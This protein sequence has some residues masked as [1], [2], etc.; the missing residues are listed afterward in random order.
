MGNA[1]VKVKV[2]AKKAKDASTN[3][4]KPKRHA[5]TK[6]ANAMISPYKAQRVS[7]VL[8][9][10]SDPTRIAIL[11]LLSNG[12]RSDQSLSAALNQSPA[13]FGPHLALLGQ[14]KLV[15]A[16]K[17]AARNLYCLT[18]Q[19]KRLASF[20]ATI[21]SSTLVSTPFAAVGSEIDP[22]LL[23]DVGEIIEN[24]EAWFNTPNPAFEGRRPRELLGTADETRLR[25]QIEAAKYGMF[26]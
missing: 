11:A 23:K 5:G 19:G 16:R 4:T 18:L 14:A 6:P 9:N 20:L 3:A 15:A 2:A 1:K 24:P 7:N 8:R 25:N 21:S 22:G 13:A 12:E 26:S 17:K 10:L